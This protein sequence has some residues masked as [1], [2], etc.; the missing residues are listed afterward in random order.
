MFRLDINNLMTPSVSGHLLYVAGALEC[1]KCRTQHDLPPKGVEGFSTN[2]TITNLVEL[3]N[4]HT[5]EDSLTTTPV[6]VLKC[7][8]EVDDN[9]AASKCLDCNYYLCEECTTLHKKQRATKHHKIAS[10]TEIKK[11]GVRQ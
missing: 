9:P 3:L 7:E 2:F 11:G 1:P 10:L 6:A 4:I 5:D 8:N